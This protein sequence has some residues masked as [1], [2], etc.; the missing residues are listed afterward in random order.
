MILF[1]SNLNA[2]ISELS[3]KKD[4]IVYYITQINDQDNSDRIKDRYNSN[5]KSLIKK[6]LEM[7]SFESE[8]LDSIKYL[9]V[10]K[11]DDKKVKLVTWSYALSFG[12]SK[13][14][15]F[16]Q[17]I[18]N[19]VPVVIELTDKKQK[20]VD[21]FSLRLDAST[22]YGMIYY[23]IITVKK[24]GMTYYTLLGFTAKDFLSNLKG[25]EILYFDYNGKAQF[26]YPIFK[27]NTYTAFRVLF[28]YAENAVM[29]LRYEAKE[30]M[31]IFDHLSPVDP[32]Y[33]G[34]P[35]YYGPDFSYD[36]FFY[37]NE[38]WNFKSDID[39][40]NPKRK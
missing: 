37:S 25:I 13:H 24:R 16:I 19:K 36:A 27:K 35:K 29:L 11:S 9:S 12:D 28:E 20:D 33:Y 34:N 6:E 18:N 40:R 22:W 5:L 38:F 17:Y 2:N 3:F 10:L 23:D 15:G 4:S 32:I 8:S 39:I 30:G 7:S 21:Y 26:G 31:I 1:V 14:F